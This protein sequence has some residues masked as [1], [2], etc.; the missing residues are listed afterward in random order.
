MTDR[1]PPLLSS[2]TF[3]GS[4]PSSR[5]AKRRFASQAD[6]TFFTPADDA[7]NPSP[8]QPRG[9]QANAQ[10]SANRS[11]RSTRDPNV[12][13]IPVQPELDEPGVLFI[14]APFYDFPGSEEHPEGLTYVHLA[15][16]PNWFLD[17]QDFLS[18]TN[19]DPS[20][21]A[22]PADE[23]KLRCTFCRRTYLGVNAKSMWRRHVYEKHKIAM[24]NRRENATRTRPTANKENKARKRSSAANKLVMHGNVVEIDV[25]LSSPQPAETYQ[26]TFHAVEQSKVQDAGE[27]SLVSD[28]E[29]EQ[30]SMTPPPSLSSGMPVLSQST[31]S[32]D[33]EDLRLE[34]PPSP[35][36][37][38]SATPEC[39]HSSPPMHR[40]W[41]YMDP[42]HPYHRFQDVSLVQLAMNSPSTAGASPQILGARTPF[43]TLARNA[44][45]T[46][47]RRLPCAPLPVANRIARSMSTPFTASTMSSGGDDTWQTTELAPSPMSKCD[48]DYILEGAWMRPSLSLSSPGMMSP[49]LRR[50][51]SLQYDDLFSSG[52]SAGQGSMAGTSSVEHDLEAMPWQNLFT[53]TGE[54][55]PSP[56]K[57][58]KVVE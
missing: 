56:P 18:E 7:F 3:A 45:E 49:V 29:E 39:R 50:T 38:P 23:P 1:R 53:E 8:Y 19:N 11:T 17:A 26:S 6:L 16:N 36:Y 34:I 41:R 32:C 37:D 47:T 40:P 48:M 4:A 57:K 42:E 28:H 54:Q 30:D 51:Q 24:A 2:A 22:Y 58:R 15:E 35:I 13:Q 52:S 44:Y 10:K 25:S 33:E 46:P 31:S 20:A 21:V 12:P 55:R 5:P 43:G 9:Q 27:Q 14:R